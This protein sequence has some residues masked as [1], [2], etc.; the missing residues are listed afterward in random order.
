MEKHNYLSMYLDLI[1]KKPQAR[2][3]LPME[4]SQWSKH[5]QHLLSF[6]QICYLI[7]NLVINNFGANRHHTALR[8][9]PIQQLSRKLDQF[10][11]RLK[12][13]LQ[14]SLVHFGTTRQNVNPVTRVSNIGGRRLGGFVPTNAP[15]FWGHSTYSYVKCSARQRSPN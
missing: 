6:W 4:P 7:H 9:C 1:R 11:A 12:H 5:D 2:D 13:L 14:P 3:L 8:C 10:L 15:T